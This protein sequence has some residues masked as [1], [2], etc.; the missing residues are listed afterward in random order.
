MTCVLF[1]Q[2]AD[3]SQDASLKTNTVTFTIHA[4]GNSNGRIN[5]AAPRALY[6][7]LTNTAGAPL[8]TYQK[9]TILPLGNEFVTEP[10]TLPEG[11]YR[12]TDFLLADSNDSILYATP[13]SGSALEKAVEKSLPYEF[14]VTTNEVTNLAMQVI[15]V[16]KHG[17]QALGYASFKIG[18]VNPL[19]VSVFT[20]DADDALSL[21]SATAVILLDDDTVKRFDLAA[22]KNTISF[23][24]SGAL[25]YT[26]V[27][28]KSGYNIQRFTFRYDTLQNL[29]FNAYLGEPLKI[30]LQINAPGDGFSLYVW[31]HTNDFMDTDIWVDYGDGTPVVHTYLQSIGHNYTTPGK[32]RVTVIGDLDSINEFTNYF[33]HAA[34]FENVNFSS[35]KNLGYVGLSSVSGPAVLDFRENEIGNLEIV[36]NPAVEQIHFPDNYVTTRIFLQKLDGINTAAVDHIINTLYNAVVST[37]TR[38]GVFGILGEMDMNTMVLIGPPSYEERLKMVSLRDDYGWVA[39]PDPFPV[40]G[41]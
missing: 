16:T 31:A 1:W 28:S 30:D 38:N 4:A 40:S 20:R 17:A 26:L 8:V 27:V 24:G 34:V 3:E 12:I 23:P 36:N 33:P 9:I 35:L 39:G 37:N 21:T 2:C 10:L 22:A 7:S 5:A 29:E 19:Q 18:V 11:S 32:Y 13:K 14:T 41:K 15:E 6:V 25:P